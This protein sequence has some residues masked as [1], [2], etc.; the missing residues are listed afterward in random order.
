[1]RYF[2]H[3]YHVVRTKVLVE[4]DNHKQAIENA[5]DALGEACERLFYER[6]PSLEEEVRMAPLIDTDV[7]PFQL[8]TESAEEVTGYMVDEVG[9]EEY[10]NSRH[11]DAGGSIEPCSASVLLRV[12]PEERDTLLAALRLWQEFREGLPPKEEWL[13]A[14]ASNGDTHPPLENEDVDALSE[15]I[16]LS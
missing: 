8:Q 15:R 12:T 10:E 7:L 11:Y 4:A 13:V 3:I 16:N 6:Y 1:M 5:E 2:V 14:I 9:D